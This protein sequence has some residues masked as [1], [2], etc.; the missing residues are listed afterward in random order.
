MNFSRRLIAIIQN[1]NCDPQDFDK[2][3]K[4]VCTWQKR[5]ALATLISL[6]C[7]SSAGCNESTSSNKQNKTIDTTKSLSNND[8]FFPIGFY[9]VSWKST[10]EQRLQALQRIAAA[11]FNTIHASIVSPS[12]LEAYE[13]FLDEAQK[14]GVKVI[15]E[16]GV[17]RVYT[18]NKFKNKPAVLGWNIADD[19]DN[20]KRTPKE[21]CESHQQVKEI[22]PNRPTYISG[23]SSNIEQFTNCADTV[24]MQAYPIQFGKIYE[25]PSIYPHISLAY[26]ASKKHNRKLYAN[27]Q[28]FSWL[29]EKPGEE[30]Y[31]GMRAPTSMEVRNM[32]YQSL[33]AG[34]KGIIFYAFQGDVWSL[35]SHRSLWKGVK[36]LAPEIKQLSPTLLSGSFKQISTGVEGTLAG[37]WIY[38]NQATVVAINTANNSSKSVSLTLPLTN[39]QSVSPMFANR[40]SGMVLEGSKLSGLIKPKD[41]HVYKLNLK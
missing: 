16:F 4:S 15:S 20:G 5:I 32:A 18:I 23:Y 31:L 7:T 25:L 19:V 33:L 29:E 28:T 21:V 13:K 12:D 22:D 3:T 26:N 14:L 34:A 11:G 2:A 39:V 10:P 30:K 8:S 1:Q 38:Q 40:P 27:L 37:V 41:V 9:H 17:D 35:E 24:G 6:L 36:S